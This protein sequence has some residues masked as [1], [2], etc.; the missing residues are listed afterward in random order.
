MDIRGR[1]ALA[2]CPD[3][4]EM[5]NVGSRPKE[6]LRFTCSNCGAFLEIINLQPLELD[7]AFSELDSDW[8]PDEE[9]WDEEEWSAEEWD[10]E[11]SSTDGRDGDYWEP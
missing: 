6:G 9:D 10:D 4:G 7:W 3:C 2:P 8:E 11:A 1:T 5:V